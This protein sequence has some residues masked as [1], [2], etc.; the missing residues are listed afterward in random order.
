MSV[1]VAKP[2][3]R[4][5]IDPYWLRQFSVAEYHRMVETGILTPDHRVELLEGWIVNKMP[6]NP[7]HASSVGRVRR[8]ID[9]VLP[10]N[11]TMRIQVP[12]TLS[13]SEPEPDITLA[14]GEEEIYDTRHPEPSDL[15]VLIEIGDSSVIDDRRYKG[16]LYAKAKVPEFWLAN[17]VDRVVEVRTRPRGGKYQK[18]T[19]YTEKQA[20]PLIL[21][22][23]KIA[24]IPVH[25]S[26]PKS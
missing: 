19:E 18:K 6:Q 17:L 5:M 1:T 23:K 11:W 12:I 9:R 3:E 16:E 20:V 26:M 13:D 22:G 2:L 8:R 24:E 7:P 14:R 4:I 10:E 15:G 25:E 21:D